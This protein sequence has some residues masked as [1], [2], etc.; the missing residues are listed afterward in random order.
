MIISLL[1]QKGG[2]GKT[3]LAIHIAAYLKSQGSK[4]LLIDADPQSS[5]LDWKAARQGEPLVPVI[6]MPKPIIH[7]EV[8]EHTPHYDHI[9]IDGP[10]RNDSLVKSVIA[11]SDVVLIPVAPS[12]YDVWAASEIVRLI[13][14]V[15]PFKPALKTLFMINRKIV[16]TVIGRSVAKALQEYPYPTL[17]KAVCQ[18]VAFAETAATGSTVLETEPKGEASHEIRTLVKEL[19]KTLKP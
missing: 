12:P 14:E 15:A 19:M 4:V 13:E 9:I 1:N 17:S 10:P 3:T 6:G 16:N 8:H 11:A 7:T 2:V 5:A 18:R